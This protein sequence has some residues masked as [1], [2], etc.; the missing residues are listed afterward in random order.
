MVGKI[1]KKIMELFII[2][3]F[4]TTRHLSLP[5]SLQSHFTL[6]KPAG[7]D[8][9][10]EEGK[11][12]LDAALKTLHLTDISPGTLSRLKAGM[13]HAGKEFPYTIPSKV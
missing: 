9:K 4:H 11:Q 2:F 13:E 10:M 5:Y 1:E 12:V 7:D 8:K 6:C 3:T